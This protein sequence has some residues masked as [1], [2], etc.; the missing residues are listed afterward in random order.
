VVTNSNP[1]MTSRTIDTAYVM[2]NGR[3]S[4]PRPWRKSAATTSGTGVSFNQ[5]R[6]A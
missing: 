4:T 6:A 3:R 2:V 1:L 5:Q